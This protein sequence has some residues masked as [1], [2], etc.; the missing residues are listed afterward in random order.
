MFTEVIMKYRDKIVKLEKDVREIEQTE[1]EEKE[2]RATE[3]QINKANN[4][5]ENQ[6]SNLKRDWFQSHKE[7]MKEKGINYK[8]IL[9]IQSIVVPV[10]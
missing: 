2:M 3:N 10:Q 5:L 9:Y 4:I 7:R 6:P 8:C 1:Q